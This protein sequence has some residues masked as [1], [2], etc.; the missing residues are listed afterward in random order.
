MPGIFVS[1]RRKDTAGHAGR[2]FDRLRDHFGANRVFRDVDRLKPGDD[3]VEALARAVDSCD[4][5]I[6]VI[7]RDWVEARNER[8]ER[9]LDDP[10]DFIRLEVETALRRKVLVLP[11]LVE[12]AAMPETSDLPE[13]LRPLARRQAIELSEH[14]WDF[15][16]QQ[17]LSRIE[18]ATGTQRRVRKRVAF[19]TAAA[20]A[21]LALAAV[22]TSG[23]WWP[24][25]NITGSPSGPAQLTQQGFSPAQPPSDPRA[26]KSSVVSSSTTSTVQPSTVSPESPAGSR[27]QSPPAQPVEG[28]TTA[29]PSVVSSST[30]STVLPPGNPEPTP[31][32]T[33]PG[34]PSQKPTTVTPVTVPDLTGQPARTAF[35]ELKNRGLRWKV[36]P[37]SRGRG[38]PGTVFAQRP[39]ADSQIEP[40]GLINLYVV[41]SLRPNERVAGSAYLSAGRVLDLDGDNEGKKGWDVSFE[42]TDQFFLSFAN[43]AQGAFMPTT[44][45]RP[46]FDP[47]SCERV[48]PTATRLPVSDLTLG[49]Q[50]CVRTTA[51]RTAAIFFGRLTS[52]PPE[53]LVRYATLENTRT[54]PP[55]STGRPVDSARPPLNPELSSPPVQTCAQSVQG[56]I[57]WDYSGSRTWAPGNVERLCSGA[58]DDQPARCFDRVMH[59]G[60][61][62]GGGVRWE[63]PNAID[64]CEGAKNADL[65]IGCFQRSINAGR[66]MRDAI[67]ACD[68]RRSAA[69]KR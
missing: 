55:A 57:E 61:N 62:W 38:E 5:F 41:A 9:R 25:L 27:D 35:A 8:G 20:V 17:L 48:R 34:R 31:T 54:E 15:D 10:Q 60:I 28:S 30:T 40:D 52:A 49:Q 37:S 3:F 64:L 66:P 24:L 36:E 42:R 53:L 16:V 4:V 32:T 14:R 33:P 45:D 39:S 1:Y 46:S 67:A 63:W 7:G 69:R 68:E 13:D 59:G 50:V 12:A 44:P 11:V 65:T 19:W 29:K 22:A 43:G 47:A 23:I 2:L 58:A 26:A 6:L 21:A 18:E 51:G 56:R